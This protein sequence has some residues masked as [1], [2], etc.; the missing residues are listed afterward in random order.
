MNYPSSCHSH[1][2]L[3]LPT[4]LLTATTIIRCAQCWELP[5]TLFDQTDTG[6]SEPFFLGPH[7]ALC[8][9]IAQSQ[10]RTLLAKS[11]W[12][13]ILHL[14]HRT[15]LIHTPSLMYKFLTFPLARVLLSQLSKTPATVDVL[16]QNFPIH[17]PPSFCLLAISPQLPL[18]YWEWSPI[19]SPYVKSW[20]K[21]SVLI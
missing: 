6:S 14:W 15:F 13:E 18:L 10:Q 4:E 20:I 19:S 5:E 11:V 8:R 21:S 1:T 17:W 12:W 3:P 2:P 7:P 16:S 9:C